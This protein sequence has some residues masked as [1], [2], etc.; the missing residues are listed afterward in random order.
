MLAHKSLAQKTFCV[1]YVKRQ[2]NVSLK[3]ILERWI[4]FLRW[5]QK[6]IFFD[7]TLCADIECL[8]VHSDIFSEFLD[9]LK[10][11]FE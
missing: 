1:H 6:I 2:K 9:I 3:A 7:E 11:D 4:F 10:Y 5:P 8:G